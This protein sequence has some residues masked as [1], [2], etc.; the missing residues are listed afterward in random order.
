[1][2]YNPLKHHRRSTRLRGFDYA[3]PGAYFVTVCVENG[4]RAS[5]KLVAPGAMKH[6]WCGEII[7]AQWESLSLAYPH[8][9]LDEYVVMPDHF[10]A[11]LW[12]TTYDE[13][14][15][16]RPSLSA[17]MGFGKFRMTQSI[18]E[19]R[20]ERWNTETKRV[21][22]RGF[23]DRILRTEREVEFVRRY[24]REN[25]QRAYDAENP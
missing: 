24:I 18:N 8:L 10:H 3:S 2:A 22:Q 14:P 17:I 9:I 12:L 13:H 1:M 19:T 15:A 11:L 7:L 4:T 20:F 23:Y 16:P 5:G 6:N 25:P 21:L